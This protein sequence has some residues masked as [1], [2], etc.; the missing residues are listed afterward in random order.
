MD[1]V[2]LPLFFLQIFL[3]SAF[4]PY[5]FVT[6]SITFPWPSHPIPGFRDWLIT[7]VSLIIAP[8]YAVIGPKV[9]YMAPNCANQGLLDF[10]VWSGRSGP[11]LGVGVQKRHKGGKPS[12]PLFGESLSAVERLEQRESRN[13]RHCNPEALNLAS[14]SWSPSSGSVS[15][16]L[17]A[18]LASFL[19]LQEL[20]NPFW[21]K[22]HWIG[23]LKFATK[24]LIQIKM[25]PILLQ[26]RKRRL[27]CPRPHSI[28]ELPFWLFN[29]LTGMLSLKLELPGLVCV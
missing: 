9:S 8:P 18:L 17:W 7:W 5:T 13:Q 6:C 23:F 29:L 24:I 20:I 19:L 16:I 14:N 22:P 11:A 26:T 3:I 21:L 12:F 10:S 25:P 1:C 27:T 15:L 2:C 28:T 4:F